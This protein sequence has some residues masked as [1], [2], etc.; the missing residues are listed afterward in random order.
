[1]EFF[2]HFLQSFI[3]LSLEMSF[4]LL[5]G[6]LFAG[7]LHAFIRT[8]TI[9]RHLGGTG[10][11]SVLKATLLGIPL[12]LCSCGV[13]PTALAFHKKGASKSA[14]ISFL[15]STPQTGVDSI[16]ATYSLLGLPFAI[17]R[18]VVA[19]V[20]GI[21]GGLL[22]KRIL[23]SEDI[24][25][26]KDLS[27]RQEEASTSFF[28]K[29]H[30]IFRYGFIEFMDDLAKWLILGITLAALMDVI[31]PADFFQ[32]TFSNPLLQMLLVLAA[33]IPIYVCAT[34]SIPI[35]MVLMMK[36]LSPGAALVFLMA[37]P[38]INIA[39]ITVI[40]KALGRKATFAYLL[41]ISTFAIIFGIITDYLLP[42]D[43]FVLH[44]AAEHAHH[45]RIL[46]E[47]AETGTAVLLGFLLLLSFIRKSGLLKPKNMNLSSSNDEIVLVRV[48]GM[49]CAHC[50]AT[51]EKSL[52]KLPWIEFAEA[53]FTNET[54]KI[55][56]KDINLNQ[57][58]DEIENAG[59]TYQGKL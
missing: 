31:I 59:Y 7:I 53:D 28:T 35:A 44:H 3:R 21:G 42:A 25:D 45:H 54:V 8:E 47:W 34:G 50:K 24:K 40:G 52:M 23:I 57:V 19:L 6:F 18:P 15:I 55:S 22:S 49:N 5:L 56:G 1:M 48:S 37:G 20:S 39:S 43:W 2:T 46:P 14:A 10:I 11:S 58:K 12:P 41:A 16:L 30:R 13:I 32:N 26:I 27:N 17:L 38:A 29:I 33:A 36:G 4:W 51:V 9:A